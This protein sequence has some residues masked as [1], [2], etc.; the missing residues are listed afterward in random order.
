MDESINY[1]VVV[2][3][4]GVAGL[5]AAVSALEAGARVAVLDPHQLKDRLVERFRLL[6]RPTRG[7]DAPDGD[8][9]PQRLDTAHRQLS[10]RGMR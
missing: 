2:V 4:S 9:L 8:A 3:G 1:D 6:A 7:G 10:A 5:T